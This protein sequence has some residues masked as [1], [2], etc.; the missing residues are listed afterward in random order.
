VNIKAGVISGFVA[1]VV[2]SA[3]MV[4]KD[5]MGVMPELNAVHM[6]ADMM[7]QPMA[8]GWVAHFMIG[9]IVWGGLFAVLVNKLLGSNL[10]SAIIFSGIPTSIGGI[11]LTADATLA[12][13]EPS[14]SSPGRQLH[15]LPTTRD[16]SIPGSQPNPPLD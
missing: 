4:M 6:M 16:D 10:V 11:F 7:K 14:E 5:M 12:S 13:P 8:M 2:L 15:A 1:T 9:T 3:L